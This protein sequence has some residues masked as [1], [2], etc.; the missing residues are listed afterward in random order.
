MRREWEKAVN[1]P[2]KDKE[3][4]CRKGGMER[5]AGNTEGREDHRGGLCRRIDSWI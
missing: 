3:S 2:R 4:N 1:A 5:F